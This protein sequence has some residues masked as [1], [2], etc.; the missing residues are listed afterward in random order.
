LVLPPRHGRVCSL[1]LFALTVAMTHGR[2]G[3][4]LEVWFVLS[5]GFV[6]GIGAWMVHVLG[7]TQRTLAA[8]AITDPLTG[9]FNRRHMEYCLAHAVERRT[10]AAEPASLLLVDIDH[11]KRINDTHGHVAGDAV[12]KALVALVLARARKVDVLF[13]TGGDEF[14]LL[15]TGATYAH[16][17]AVADDL[18]SLVADAIFPERIRLSISVGISELRSGRHVDSW[19][20]EADAALYRAK[21]GGRNRVAGNAFGPGA[22]PPAEFSA[23]SWSD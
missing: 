17:V 12:L 23:A 1:T 18:R 22:I 4:D 7:D 14:A 19:I 16:A 2:I 11:F 9:A 21:R 10:R 3:A 20:E 8:Q 15:L 5:L 6:A 13:R